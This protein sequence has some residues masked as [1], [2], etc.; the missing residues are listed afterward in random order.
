MA[1][2]TLVDWISPVAIHPGEMLAEELEARGMSTAEGAHP[3]AKYN[4]HTGYREGQG[5]LHYPSLGSIV[6]AELG[7][8]E[9][10]L[11]NY[12][13]IGNRSYDAGFLPPRNN[14]LIVTD[15]ARGVQDFAERL[16]G[17]LH[18]FPG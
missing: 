7:K 13:S 3:R 15:P 5:G 10:A 17:R 16:D 8:A 6:S 9:F 4:L 1:T 18:W 14:P 2:D 12:V 11:P